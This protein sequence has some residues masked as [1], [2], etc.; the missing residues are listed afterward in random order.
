M[1]KLTETSIGRSR[2]AGAAALSATALLLACLVWPPTPAAANPAGAPL[3]AGVVVTQIV[4][5]G[6]AGTGVVY[7]GDQIT[8]TILIT[9]NG[10]SAA[11][12]ILVIDALPPDAL[13]GIACDGGCERLAE[14][15]VF[16]E[17]TGGTV[18]VTIT[19]S[20]SWTLTSLP[21][22][23]QVRKTV[24]GRVTGQAD[25]TVVTNR[26]F[27]SYSDGNPSSE[28]RTTV[29]VRIEQT[30]QSGLS[31]VPTWFSKDQGGTISQ[32]WGDF[33]RDGSLDLALASSV[34][35]GV[36]RNEA[37]HLVKSRLPSRSKSPQS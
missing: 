1:P 37:G 34:G 4:E 25:G 10:A 24:T 33:D 7:N 29:R 30:G 17:P 18:V 31:S 2:L 36:Y 35:L 28:A 32:D 13:D 3:A 19:R 11:A 22:G 15:T 23:A 6:R 26:V 12:D 20:I 8:Y 16:P 9:N 5:T 21:P 27:L 14:T